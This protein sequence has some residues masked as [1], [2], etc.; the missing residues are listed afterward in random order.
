MVRHGFPVWVGDRVHAVD[1]AAFSRP[2]PEPQDQTSSAIAGFDTGLAADIEGAFDTARALAAPVAAIASESSI[3]LWSIGAVGHRE[4][5]YGLAYQDAAAPPDALVHQLAPRN[6]LAAK[7][8]TYQQALFPTDV[9]GLLQA[10]RKN[11][12]GR[13]I[14]LVENAASHLASGSPLTTP[15]AKQRELARISRL[16]IGA[17]AALMVSDKVLVDR[18]QRPETILSRAQQRFGNY[19]S[20]TRQLHPVD[21]DD[22]LW[23]IEEPWA[24]CQ[25]RGPGP[26]GSRVGL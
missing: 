2:S 11:S 20:W 24:R 8:A 17:M 6:L 14:R 19:F 25:L 21:R 22:L 13:L 16:L 23:A 15:L 1:V 3:D 10:A 12:A 26:D 9:A 5:L 18:S 7:N 4:R